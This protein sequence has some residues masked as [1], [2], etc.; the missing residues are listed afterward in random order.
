MYKRIF[1]LL[2]FFLS[3][4]LFAQTTEMKAEVLYDE[5]T[6]NLLKTFDVLYIADNPDKYLMNKSP[7]SHFNGYRRIYSD[8]VIIHGNSFKL[9]FNAEGDG[10]KKYEVTRV[11]DRSDTFLPFGLPFGSAGNSEK[12][13]MATWLLLNTQLYLC[14]VHF[15]FEG[16]RDDKIVYP[17]ME[18]FTGKHFNRKNIPDI[19]IGEWIYGLM[20]ATWFTDT[21]YVKKANSEKEPLYREVWQRKHYLRMIF[22]KGKLVS[23]EVVANKTWIETLTWPRSGKEE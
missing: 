1:L 18:K 17:P 7:L 14:R 12:E 4:Q 13:Y 15:P 9:S 19:E 11:I 16:K 8:T 10:K 3:F 2:C 22:N 5:F 23:T 20:P 6:H 21:L